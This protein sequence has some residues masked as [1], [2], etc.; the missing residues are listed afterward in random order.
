M[1]ESVFFRETEP[2]EGVNEWVNLFVC[3]F[4][5][6]LCGYG[7]WEVL[8][9]AVRSWRAQVQ[10]QRQEE[11]KVLARKSAE[12]EDSPLLWLFC[13]VQGSSEL[14]EPSS[15]RG[16]KPAAIGLPNLIWKH[17]HRHTQKMSNQISGHPVTWSNEHI[18]SSTTPRA[19]LRD[20]C[21]Q[22]PRDGM[23]V[24]LLRKV[25][26]HLVR[27]G[28]FQIHFEVWPCGGRGWRWHWGFGCERV[29]G[30]VVLEMANTG[31]KSVWGSEDKILLWTY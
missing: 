12:R 19:W 27:C 29:P 22:L 30:I 4:G 18:R 17:P 25:A 7:S 28:R 21:I 20:E 23:I 26:L 2:T 1:C 3:L 9:P 6:G 10:V 16:G 13:S 14:H 11:T 31:E 5:I 8:W 24:A 15:Q